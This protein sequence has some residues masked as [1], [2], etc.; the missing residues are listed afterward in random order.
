MARQ[1][2]APDN[3]RKP[4]G[5][6]HDFKVGNTIYTAGEVGIDQDG[7]IVG[8]DDFP[9]QLEQTLEN[10]KRVLEAGGATMANIV[11]MTMF[12]TDYG[13]LAKAMAVFAK[14]FE[15]PFAPATAVQISALAQPGLL[16]EINAIAVV[17]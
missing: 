6:S 14:Y 17:D 10:L 8:A 2:I 3:V 9:R 1:V 15:A 16:I 12:L 11:Q 7:N 4:E 13:N 5:D